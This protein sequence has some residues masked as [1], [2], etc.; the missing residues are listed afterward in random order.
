ME[1]LQNVNQCLYLSSDTTGNWKQ[2]VVYKPNPK[3]SKY[4]SI[5]DTQEKLNIDTLISSYYVR[6]LLT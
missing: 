2:G 6:S 3:L 1:T 5:A 4:W